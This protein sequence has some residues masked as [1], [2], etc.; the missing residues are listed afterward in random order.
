MVERYDGESQHKI[1]HATCRQNDCIRKNGTKAAGLLPHM[2]LLL[3]LVRSGACGSVH[4]RRRHRC[5]GEERGCCHEGQERCSPRK[6][7]HFWRRPLDVKV[8][9]GVSSLPKGESGWRRRVS[10]EIEGRR[11]YWFG[12]LSLSPVGWLAFGATKAKASEPRNGRK[13]RATVTSNM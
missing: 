11:R 10:P 8:S 2:V 1:R 12:A 6:Q 13:G 3:Y 5:R 9:M 7:K 4:V